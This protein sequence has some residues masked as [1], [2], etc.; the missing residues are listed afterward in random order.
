MALVILHMFRAATACGVTFCILMLSLV[1]GIIV[2]TEVKC[3]D[4]DI[5][6]LVYFLSTAG[7][8]IAIGAHSCSLV[9]L[10]E[11]LFGR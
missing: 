3:A 4:C 9:E 11:L 1:T 5:I 7:V 2:V 8:A 6:V 10:L